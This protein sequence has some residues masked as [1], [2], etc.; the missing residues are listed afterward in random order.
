MAI[1]GGERRIRFLAA[2]RGVQARG[3]LREQLAQV[4]ES[5][6]RA[7]RE[8]GEECPEPR[9]RKAGGGRRR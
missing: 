3:D 9:L 1:E 5:A 6:V 2:A 4:S 8:V 7:A